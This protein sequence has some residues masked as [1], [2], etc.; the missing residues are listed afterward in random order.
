[1]R[2]FKILI[3]SLLSIVSV[4]AMAQEELSLSDAIQRGLEQNYDISIER[5]NVDI[6]Q[7]NN[8]WGE[9]G[10][11]PTISLN[12]NQNN[13][14]TD[15][16]KTAGPF[17]LQD[18]TIS[19]SLN[20]TVN[21]NWTLFNGFK[22]N[23]S[24]A[25][26]EDLQ[27]ESAGNADIVIANTIQSI[28]LGYY[29]VVLEKRRLEEF[30]R[31]LKL[32]RDKY[33]YTKIKSDLGSAVSTD[34]LIEEDNYLTDSTNFINQQ[35]VYRNTVRD[36]NFILAEDNV[37]KRYEFTDD[38][39]YDEEDYKLEDLLVKLNSKN[40]DLK[41]Q[42]ISQQIMTHNLAIAKADR[43]PT[44]SLNSG[45]SH[46]RSRVD[47]SNATFPSQD[48]STSPGPSEPLSA[49]TDN[50]FANFTISFTLFNGNK[51]NRAIQNAMVNEDIANITTTR[52]KTSLYRDLAK[53][54]DQYE[55]RKQLYGIS[56]RKRNA[57]DTNLSI[58]E[59]KFKNGSINSFD[60]RDVQNNSLL[61]ALDKL[62]ATYNLI[63][64]KVTIMRLTGGIIETYV[65]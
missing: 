60:F 32:S 45:Y 14:L 64:S 11:W 26:L 20:P 53:A 42:Y 15:N 54:H 36:L 37:D 10:R 19:N 51:I 40:V 3:L 31:Q 57:A 55:I 35:L 27:A 17:Q 43:Y 44:V 33:N 24:K 58:T 28:I 63:D 21:L 59:E 30:N 7:N 16:I 56:V 38:L 13:S 34:L 49:V 23:I 22:I 41:K 29:K 4:K 25:R 65:N 5:K 52:L 8:A 6:A 47:L 62:Q 48:G 12:L 50:Y 9:A 1:M 46:N 39:I 2:K 61:A 18:Q